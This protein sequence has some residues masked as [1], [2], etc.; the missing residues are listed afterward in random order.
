MASE[1]RSRRFEEWRE[2]AIT[3][4]D[5]DR[6]E[7]EGRIV[8]DARAAATIRRGWKERAKQGGVKSISVVGAGVNRYVTM[9]IASCQAK[10]GGRVRGWHQRVVV[11]ETIGY[12][13][14]R[15]GKPRRRVTGTNGDGEW[16]EYRAL[17]GIKGLLDLKQDVESDSL[18]TRFLPAS[19][20]TM[21]KDVAAAVRR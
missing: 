15:R 14:G 20:V 2:T 8:E 10:V 1:A 19:R 9:E 16:S 13:M 3:E 21:V 18:G 6:V 4:A 17:D 11:V 5:R 12:W 7:L